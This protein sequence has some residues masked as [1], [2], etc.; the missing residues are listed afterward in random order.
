M[1][2]CRRRQQGSSGNEAVDRNDLHRHQGLPC[3]VPCRAAVVAPDPHL[4]VWD[5]PPP[6]QS[7]GSLWRKL[8]PGQQ[9]LLVLPLLVGRRPE[10]TGGLRPGSPWPTRT[11][12]EPATPRS[13]I[14]QEQAGIPERSEPGPREAPGTRRARERANAQLKN[15]RILPK[16]PLLPPARRATRQGN[17]RSGDSRGIRS[18][19]KGSLFFGW[20]ARQAQRHIIRHLCASRSPRS[21]KSTCSS[22][23]GGPSSTGVVTLLPPAP[24]RSAANRCS[25]RSATTTPCRASKIPIFTTGTPPLTHAVICSRR[26]SNSAHPA[27]CPSGRTGPPLTSLAGQPS[28]HCGCHIPSAG[29]AVNAGLR[30][31]RPLALAREPGPQH[32]TDLDHC[33][34]RNTIPATSSRSTGEDQTGT[35]RDKRRTTPPVP[36]LATG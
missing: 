4:R 23:P 29:L 19:G 28:R 24:H 11:T 35:M 18:L 6:P 15:W 12:R 1:T 25:V 30:G 13:R 14:G 2:A 36:L 10:R 34:S 16:A 31:H 32:L 22:P 21:P 27:P 3:F 33:T 8:N 5:H 17:P 9:A 20:P 26:A 7:I